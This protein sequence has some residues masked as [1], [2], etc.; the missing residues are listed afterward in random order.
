MTLFHLFAKLLTCMLYTSTAAIYFDETHFEDYGLADVLL[1]HIPNNQRHRR[2]A[3]DM[4]DELHVTVTSDLGDVNLRLRRN[5]LADLHVPVYTIK[6]GKFLLQKTQK[7]KGGG[8][9]QDLGARASLHVSELDKNLQIFDLEGPLTINGSQFLLTPS[10]ELLSLQTKAHTRRTHKL[11]RLLKTVSFGNDFMDERSQ[12]DK[13]TRGLLAAHRET[14]RLARAQGRGRRQAPITHTIELTTATDYEVYARFLKYAGGN[15]T[16]ALSEMRMYYL[17][18]TNLMDIRYKSVTTIDPSLIIRVAMVSLVVADTKEESVWTENNKLSAN[19]IDA[20]RA[21]YTF[22]SWL[23]ANTNIPKADHWM[24]FSGHDLA[25]ASGSSSTIGIAFIG[26]LCTESSVSVIEE[27]FTATS[28]AVSAHELGHSLDAD[29]DSNYRTCSD[30]TNN[31]MSTVASFPT[32]V[33]KAS[34]PWKF[35]PCSV[36]AFGAYLQSVQ[37][38]LQPPTTSLTTKEVAGLYLNADEQCQLAMGPGSYFCRT[39]Q[40][41]MG[42]DLMCRRL[43]CFM[44]EEKTYCSSIVPQEYTSCNNKQWCQ[45][46]LCVA[47][48]D[49][50]ATIPNCPQGDDPAYNCATA[51]CG[52]AKVRDAYCCRSC[53]ERRGVTL[54]PGSSAVGTAAVGVAATTAATTTALKTTTTTTSRATT[55]LPRTTAAGSSCTTIE[56]QCRITFTLYCYL[57]YRG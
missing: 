56:C 35:S 7:M 17:F 39:V 33:E 27:Y 25:E 49:A 24:L 23:R 52:D 8:F 47:N 54:A 10:R 41:R 55:T 44:P 32:A 22:R 11:Q 36:D 26:T 9:Y 4:P 53:A 18:M 34:N 37:C 48:P 5:A 19:A 14:Q 30:S 50:P 15:A 12:Q 57:Y 45:L 28:G 1:T 51:N 2:S 20:E 40:Q 21:L 42:W 31:V 6:K 3:D 16:V 46:G 13:H 38:A 29:H 43:Y